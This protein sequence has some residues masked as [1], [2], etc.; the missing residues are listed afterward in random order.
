MRENKK[1]L[2]IILLFTFASRVI[3]LHWNSGEYTD[4]IIQMTLFT[5]AK[6]NS[7][8]P[9]LYSFLILLV[10]YLF[11]NLETSA[12]LISMLAGTLSVIPVYLIAKRLFNSRTGIYAAI[13]VAVSPEIWRWQIRVMTDSLFTF[14]FLLSIYFLLKKEDVNASKHNSKP[15]D[16]RLPTA[17]SLAFAWFF[18]GLASLTRYQGIALIPPLI[19]VTIWLIRHGKLNFKLPTT[20][21]LLPTGF[22]P[23]LILIWWVALRGFGHFGQYAERTSQ[24]WWMSLVSYLT[25]AETFVLYIPYELTYPVFCFLIYGAFQLITRKMNEQE[26]ELTELDSPVPQYSD[27]PVR[28]FNWIFIYLF[29]AWLIIHSP[30]E[31]FQYRY[32]IPIF[33]LFLILAAYGIAQFQNSIFKKIMGIIAII[34]CLLFSLTSLYLQRD[35]FGDIKRAAIVLK[36]SP[37]PMNP[38]IYGNELYRPGMSNLKLAFWSGLNIQSYDAESRT[39][40]EPGDYVVLHNVYGNLISE[41]NFLQTYYD[42]KIIYRAEAKTVPLLP[43]IMSSPPFTS[44][45]AGMIFKYFP[46]EFITVILRI[47]QKHL[48]N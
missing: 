16:C 8:Y 20:N 1:N 37:L 32:F 35:T 6:E 13:L 26:Q 45:P 2:L 29:I 22:I 46:Q 28:L 19:I 17:Y 15:A 21:C 36:E 39:Q 30:F 24:T 40:L 7:F 5:A 33:P 38:R 12:K 14:F 41:E 34:F 27:T 9:P 47:E 3:F 48:P 25:M 10:N 23:W 42:A 43:D 11:H 18:A 4:G 44:H 31:S